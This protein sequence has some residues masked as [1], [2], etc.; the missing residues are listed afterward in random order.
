M[1]ETMPFGRT[2]HNST[3]T[4]F[5]G[6]SL[7]PLDPGELD[8][9]LQLLLE[10][11]INH[12]DIAAQYGKGEAER[13]AGAWMREHRK[14]FFLATKTMERSYQKAK[15]EFHSS[16]ERL[17]VDSVDLLQ[18]HNLVYPD[19]W[20]Q[21]L[22]PK[23][24]LEALIEAKE[25]GLTRF[26]G[27]T[28]H[29]M[30]AAEMH[31]KSL[32]RYDFDSVLC[33]YNYLMMQDPKYAKDFGR[34]VSLCKEKKVAVQT[35]KSIARRPYASKRLGTTW[36]ESLS[37]QEDIEVAVSWVMG[38]PDVFLV[39]CA[40]APLLPLVLGAAERH[41]E[42]PSDQRMLSLIEDSGMKPIFAGREM[43]QPG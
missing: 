10:K 15:D 33:P 38:D 40:E 42:R 23:G 13:K 11:G 37:R 36:Y 22:G 28:G 8:R 34:L 35:I 20:E 43:V 24:A 27:V 4:I 17:K 39:T 41:A 29:G 7:S 12:I 21:A 6:A 30:T 18:M 1:I 3:R 5:G 14:R 31:I 2:G 9:V 19:E 16:L 25:Q 32:E 26:L